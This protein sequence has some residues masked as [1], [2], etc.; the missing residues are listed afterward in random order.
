[1]NLHIEN[2]TVGLNINMKE[3]EIVKIIVCESIKNYMCMISYSNK[4]ETIVITMGM[5]MIMIVV[6]IIISNVLELLQR[7]LSRKLPIQ[8]KRKFT[9]IFSF[10][11]WIIISL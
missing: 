7:F 6:L 11:K 5:V 3:I 8:N 9:P 1:K 10:T 4:D 2:Y